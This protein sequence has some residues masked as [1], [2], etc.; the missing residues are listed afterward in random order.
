MPWGQDV[1]MLSLANIDEVWWSNTGLRQ[2]EASQRQD[3]YAP[4]VTSRGLLDMIHEF[5]FFGVDG[6]DT[7]GWRGSVLVT[8][9]DSQSTFDRWVR[10][11]PGKNCPFRSTN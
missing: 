5:G 11:S 6:D 3:Y 8:S 2:W 1:E 9:T 10:G 7:H 4:R